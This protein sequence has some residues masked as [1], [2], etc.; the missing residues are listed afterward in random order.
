MMVRR[1]AAS[2]R[3]VARCNRRSSVSVFTA[4]ANI[5]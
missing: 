3:A 1:I 4:R 2:L 5:S